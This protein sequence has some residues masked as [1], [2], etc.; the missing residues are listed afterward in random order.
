MDTKDMKTNNTHIYG[1]YEVIPGKHWLAV[2]A[3]ESNGEKI[4][5]HQHLDKKTKGFFNPR[6]CIKKS[7]MS[8]VNHSVCAFYG[9]IDMYH[10]VL[11]IFRPPSEEC[12][13]KY[14]DEEG[15]VKEYTIKQDDVIVFI[16]DNLSNMFHITEKDETIFNA[17]EHVLEILQPLSG[18]KL[19]KFLEKYGKYLDEL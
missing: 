11:G 6:E 1:I 13:V 18:E 7:E 4:L 14:K 2:Y 17:T 9:R 5:T 16:L 12:T 10:K 3:K 19:K 15:K 8:K